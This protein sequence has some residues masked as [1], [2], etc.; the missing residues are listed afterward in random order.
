LINLHSSKCRL[1]VRN[2]LSV[3]DAFFFPLYNVDFFVKDQL[4][5]SVWG[6]F[7][8]FSPIILID[9]SASIKKNI[10]FFFLSPF[11][12]SIAWDHGGWFLQKFF[13]CWELF[14]LSWVFWIFVCLLFI[15]IQELLFPC[16]W[17]IV[18]EF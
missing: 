5:I 17:R 15:W 14:T 16:L 1:Q 3:E 2:V 11:P 8:L 12:C 10:M 7:C 13:Y 18:L 6:Y 9:L 4:F